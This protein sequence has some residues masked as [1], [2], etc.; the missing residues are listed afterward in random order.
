MKASWRKWG[1]HWRVMSESLDK[2]MEYSQRNS[3]QNLGALKQEAINHSYLRRCMLNYKTLNQQ[4]IISTM[5]WMFNWQNKTSVCHSYR[6]CEWKSWQDP[7]Q[8]VL[9]CLL[10]LFLRHP[11][12]CQCGKST[13]LKMNF[14]S[15]WSKYEL[16]PTQLFNWKF[17]S[18]CY[19]GEHS[20]LTI[21]F[22]PRIMAA[23]QWASLA[24][25][26]WE[27]NLLCDPPTKAEML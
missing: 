27:R 4:I 13:P 22:L 16:P 25:L 10:D 17:L 14:V 15:Q 7:P 5:L 6:M 2:Q 18:R 9:K 19:Q 24:I 20:K 1:N 23:L 21:C 8:P 12:F 26:V 11:K 3:Q